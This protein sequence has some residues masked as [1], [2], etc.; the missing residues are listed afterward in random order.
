MKPEI[1]RQIVYWQNVVEQSLRRA[2]E[3]YHIGMT[4]RCL[5]ALAAAA[6]CGVTA[7]LRMDMQAP[8]PEPKVAHQRPDTYNPGPIPEWTP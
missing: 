4:D 8:F 5:R 7:D 1:T 2:N 3:H 6:G